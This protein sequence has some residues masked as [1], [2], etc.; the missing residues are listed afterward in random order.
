MSEPFP[1]FV[2]I[3]IVCVC[4][5]KISSYSMVADTTHAMWHTSH[6]TLSAIF[7]ERMPPAPTNTEF[8]Y[9]GILEIVTDRKHV[10]IG[11]RWSRRILL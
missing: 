8:K 10:A 11:W 6:M 3:Y 5:N 7:V 4:L 9:T 1:A 2:L